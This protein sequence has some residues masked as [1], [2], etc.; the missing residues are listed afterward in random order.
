MH[1]LHALEPLEEFSMQS[2]YFL[3]DQGIVLN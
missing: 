2:F 3:I 1:V